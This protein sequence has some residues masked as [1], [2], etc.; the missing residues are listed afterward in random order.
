MMRVVSD[1]AEAPH[2]LPNLFLGT[3]G[4][5]RLLNGRAGPSGGAQVAPGLGAVKHIAYRTFCPRIS[6]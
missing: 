1:T 6:H 3:R 2:R 5:E 4:V